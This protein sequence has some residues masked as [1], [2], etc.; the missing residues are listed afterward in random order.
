M[1]LLDGSKPPGAVSVLTPAVHRHLH[2]AR[3]QDPP[4][5]NSLSLLPSPRPNAEERAARGARLG[6]LGAAQAPGPLPFHGLL[7]AC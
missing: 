2:S 7:P 5:L 3:A 4:Q 1:M 6:G